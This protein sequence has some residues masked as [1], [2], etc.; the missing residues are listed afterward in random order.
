M[1]IKISIYKEGK[2]I[3][4]C[5]PLKINKDKLPELCKMRRGG[6]VLFEIY[7]RVSSV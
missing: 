2:I 7:R 1:E 4:R 3:V 5:P 6:T